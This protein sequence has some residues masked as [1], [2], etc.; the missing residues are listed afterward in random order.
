[1]KQLVQKIKPGVLDFQT[2]V[3][4]E[5]DGGFMLFFDTYR[6]DASVRSQLKRIKKR[7]IEENSKMA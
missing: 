2:E 6:I 1:M 4:P 5:I 3:N 7:F